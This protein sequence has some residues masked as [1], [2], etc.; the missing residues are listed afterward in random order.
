METVE[1]TRYSDEELNEFKDLITKKVKSATEE[2]EYLQDQIK[3]SS[4]EV[5][6]GKFVGMDDG[7]AGTSEVEQLNK[8]AGR[9]AQYI[10]YLENALVRIE[11]KTYGLC[12][13]TGKLIKKERLMAVPH[14]TL[15]I[16]AKLQRR[17]P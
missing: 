6:D 13:V 8:L 2:L 16:E 1:K 5:A 17:K 7:G 10:Q 4:Q 11:N 9:Q 14:A 12:R 15:S 3:K